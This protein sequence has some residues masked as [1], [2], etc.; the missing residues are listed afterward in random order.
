[1]KLELNNFSQEDIGKIYSLLNKFLKE[2]NFLLCVKSYWY[3]TI[4]Q[5]CIYTFPSG[6]K[7]Y[8]G[9]ELLK[10]KA[11][12][13]SDKYSLILYP[14]MT[15]DEVGLFNMS[16]QKEKVNSIGTLNK[17]EI[18]ELEVVVNKIKNWVR[19][20]KWKELSNSSIKRSFYFTLNAKSYK[21]PCIEL[22]KK[23]KVITHAQG[24]TLLQLE[25]ESFDDDSMRQIAELKA[26]EITN[27]LSLLIRFDI[28]IFIQGGNGLVDENNVLR[29]KNY[30]DLDFKKFEEKKSYINKNGHNL[31]FIPRKISDCFDSYIELKQEEHEKFFAAMEKYSL[32]LKNWDNPDISVVY[33]VASIEAFVDDEA[34]RCDCCSKCN[35]FVDDTQKKFGDLIKRY[36]PTVYIEYAGNKYRVIDIAKRAY[37]IRSKFIHQ[38]YNFIISKKPEYPFLNKNQ[39][40]NEIIQTVFEIIVFYVLIGKLICKSK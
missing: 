33:L 18:K 37:D 1:M 40:I 36:A 29:E 8:F 7:A 38:N 13:G 11:K 10:S 28:K 3:N 16:N 25:A 30:Y 5:E 17:N 27:F 24:G 34:K 32:A 26:Q 15:T 12:K 19:K 23:I 35:A 2:N 39:T 31:L 22:S 4:N 21:L 9:Y 14:G 20:N 6:V